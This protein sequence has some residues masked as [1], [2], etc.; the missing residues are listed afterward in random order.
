MNTMRMLILSICSACIVTIWG[1]VLGQSVM[2]MSYQDGFD[3]S[4]H[5]QLVE[6]I[7]QIAE[8]IEEQSE[9]RQRM[10]RER[11]S[12]H[13][14]IYKYNKFY[15]G[16]LSYLLAQLDGETTKVA[17]QDIVEV[18]VS[19][20]SFPTL[21]AA[22]QAADLVDDLQAQGPFT[23]FA[24]TEEAFA[25]L[26]AQLDMT[27]E[28]LLAD[29]D[30]LTTVLLYHVVP[31]NVVAEEVAGL[32][33]GTLVE[34][35]QGE[36]IRITTRG[37]IMIEEADLIQTDIMASNG[38]IHVIDEVLL[39]PSII[40]ALGGTTD[41]VEM[42]IPEVA[43]DAGAFPTLVAALEAAGLVDDLQTQGPFTVYAPTEEAFADLL[44]QLD[45]TVAELLADTDLLTDVLLYHVVPA[46]FEASE[47][48]MLE[49]PVLA[50]TLEWS[51][52]TV[53]PHEGS[54]T[55][56]WCAVVDTDILA[57][58]GIIHVIDCVLVPA[59]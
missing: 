38:V 18:A 9:S 5:P 20:D 44:D 8:R 56:N 2:G 55:I 32:A 7:D 14:E 54:P 41:R 25:D 15:Q 48:V 1:A 24:P 45:M 4:A 46:R 36:S 58:N 53:D 19:S 52:I 33:N 21:V 35:L 23:V 28:E 30:L 51:S 29:T 6:A 22:L 43:I 10:I 26:L 31:G 27:A 3:P 40:E 13:Q 49:Q 47:I 17:E 12:T 11:I 57:S 42:T 34:T 59:N 50:A 37:D 39:P 16:V